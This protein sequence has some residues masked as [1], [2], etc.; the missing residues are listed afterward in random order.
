MLGS[1]ASAL[2][3]SG[4]PQVSSKVTPLAPPFFSGSP[5][6]VRPG[7]ADR[8]APIFCLVFG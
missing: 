6:P 5:R 4:P 7:G 2:T 1:S 3:S 8:G